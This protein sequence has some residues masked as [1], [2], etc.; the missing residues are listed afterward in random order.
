[1]IT[2]RVF[3]TLRSF[4]RPELSG[5]AEFSLDLTA[6]HI[7]TVR[8]KDLTVHLNI[9]SEKVNMAIINGKIITDFNQ[10]IKDGDIVALA[11]AIGGG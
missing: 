7:E 8:V 4:L 5:S 10:T 1:M 9:P 11:P 2:V 3:P 6:L